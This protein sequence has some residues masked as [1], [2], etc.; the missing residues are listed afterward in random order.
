MGSG[1]KPGGFRPVLDLDIEKMRC[2]NDRC[3]FGL[4]PRYTTG[5]FETETLRIHLEQ[6]LKGCVHL[7]PR[8]AVF[9]EC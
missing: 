4:V 8:I 7:R 3:V 6:I 1:R 5:L 9:K 2:L